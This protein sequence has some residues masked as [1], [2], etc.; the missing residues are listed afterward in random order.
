MNQT[1]IA[2]IALISFLP[3]TLFAQK[4]GDKQTGLA[5]VY[6]NRLN[7]HMVSSGQRMNPSAL[8]AANPTLPYGTRI[9]VTNLHNHRSVIVR[10]TD[11]GPTQNGRILDLTTAAAHR[12]GVPRNSMRQVEYEVLSVGNGHIYRQ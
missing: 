1:R 6:S 8:T 12:I 7:G 5:A 11:R 2:L 10:I 4:V 3:A 9:R